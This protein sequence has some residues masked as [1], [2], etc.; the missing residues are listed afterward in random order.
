MKEAL[1]ANLEWFERSGVMLPADGLWGVAE[2]VAVAQGNSAI[3]KMKQAFVAWTDHGDH[4][5]IEQRR[6]DCNFQAVYLFLLA[7]RVLDQKKYYHIGVN[8]LDFLYCRSGL[9]ERGGRSY[10]VGSWN[11]SHIKRS[12]DVWFDDQSWCLFLQLLIAQEFPELEPRYDLKKWAVTLGNEM[13]GALEEILARAK[14]LPAG[15]RWENATW[16]GHIEKPHWGALPQMALAKCYEATGDQDYLDYVRK[17]HDYLKTTADS[18]IV[19]EQAYALIG[20]IFAYKSTGDQEY[21]ELAKRIGKMIADKMD[22]TGNIP[23]EHDEAPMGPHLVDTIYTVNWALVGLQELSQFC[24]EFQTPFQKLLELVLKIQDKS[25]LPQYHGC[26][27][28]MFDLHAND[29]GGGDCY[30]GGAGSIYTG[31]TN[32]PIA[33]VLAKEILSSEKEAK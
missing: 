14:N 29:W 21:L 11:W 5:I 4:C 28:G 18:F 32:A 3:E 16:L 6:A 33:I 8:I 30:E 12:S 1:L 10:V 13:L 23:A 15:A 19:S 31:W 22:A 24:P 2:R 20:E 26:W 27:R 7:S 9:L 17:Y 25:P